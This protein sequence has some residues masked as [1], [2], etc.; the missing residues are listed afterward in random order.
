[1]RLAMFAIEHQY[2]LCL[3]RRPS[4][5]QLIL[6]LILDLI[7]RALRPF[8]ARCGFPLARRRDSFGI[9]DL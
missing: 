1:M 6:L 3:N 4:L 7:P 9:N 8:S 5:I 2:E